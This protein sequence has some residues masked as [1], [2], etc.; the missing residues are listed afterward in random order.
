M[1]V[2]TEEES[3]FGQ[4]PCMCDVCVRKREILVDSALDFGQELND[5]GAEPQNVLFA[6]KFLE[7]VLEMTLTSVGMSQSQLE[8][9]DSACE[10]YF[11]NQAQNIQNVIDEVSIAHD[12]E[13]A[14]NLALS[15]PEGEKHEPTPQ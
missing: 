1:C 9:I 12:L 13:S 14:L 5:M 7:R 8:D 11:K 2:N 3:A 6:V 10:S 4:Q 15:D